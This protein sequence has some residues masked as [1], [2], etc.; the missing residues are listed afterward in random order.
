MTNPPRRIVPGQIV[1]ECIA[2]VQTFRGVTPFSPPAGRGQS[3]EAAASTPTVLLLSPRLIVPASTI[4]KRS[5][6]VFR[7]PK[8][9]LLK[10]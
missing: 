10:D 2:P 6:W 3:S 9:E 4:V 7:T 1:P 8:L 5:L